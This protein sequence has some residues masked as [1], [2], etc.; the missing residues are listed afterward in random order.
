[1]K[2]IFESM[3]GTYTQAGDYLIPNIELPPSPSIGRW[4]RQYRRYL[5]EYHEAYYQRLLLTGQLNEHLEKID[6][7]A[8]EMSERLMTQMAAARGINE[9]LKAEDPMRWVGLMNAC[10]SQAEEIVFRE[11]IYC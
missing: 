11:L 6:A 4:G 3:G 10:K 2:S 1:M 8:E 7:R 5:K 9:Q